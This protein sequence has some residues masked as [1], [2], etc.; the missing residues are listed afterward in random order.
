[1]KTVAKTTLLLFLLCIISSCSDKD[2]KDTL[3][4]VI[5][6]KETASPKPQLVIEEDLGQY[7]DIKITDTVVFLTTTRGESAIKAF[8]TKDLSLINEFGYRG[9]GPEG[10]EFPMFIKNASNNKTVELYYINYSTLLKVSFN[11]E[12]DVYTINKTRMPDALWPSD[13]KSTRLNS[14]H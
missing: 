7:Y 6:E 5:D 2:E 14:S 1:M 11:T 9:D 4:L 13:R 12:R 8:S 10:V 3:L